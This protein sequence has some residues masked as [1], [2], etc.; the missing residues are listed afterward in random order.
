M[1]L[2][3]YPALTKLPKRQ[4]LQLAEDLWFSGIDD[5]LPVSPRHRSMLEER[6]S[7]YRKGRAKRV[8]LSELER[9]LVRT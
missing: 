9:R 6:W 3:D 5:S 7:A 1:T 4:R 8:T 2:A